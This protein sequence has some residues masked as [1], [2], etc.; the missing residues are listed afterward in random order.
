MIDKI[1]NNITVKI[2]SHNQVCVGTNTINYKVF[3]TF[4]EKVELDEEM[5]KK[6]IKASDF[7]IEDFIPTEDYKK[8]EFKVRSILEPV[9]FHSLAKQQFQAYF[10]K[11]G[12]HFS[13]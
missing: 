4:N 9:E 11:F 10:R 8:Y 13:Y 2:V 6:D 12:M 5:I 3:L 1:I 7:I